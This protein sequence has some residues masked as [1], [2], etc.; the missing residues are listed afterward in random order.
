[1]SGSVRKG[2]EH[3]K[4]TRPSKARKERKRGKR[5]NI[6]TPVGDEKK[7]FRIHM[8]ERNCMGGLGSKSLRETIG[9]EWKKERS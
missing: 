1:V 2:L 9:V 5:L 6:A 7:G 8:S 4:K 3:E